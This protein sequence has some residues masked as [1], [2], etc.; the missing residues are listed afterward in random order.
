MPHVGLRA[1]L[2]STG[3]WVFSG[4]ASIFA[5]GAY[6]PRAPAQEGNTGCAGEARLKA[7]IP[8]PVKCGI[9]ARLNAGSNFTLGSTPGFFDAELAY[10][11]R[12]AVRSNDRFPPKD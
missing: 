1:K 10:R 9:I 5:P 11:L 2:W 8:H 4:Q 3:E 7:I 6:N 12:T